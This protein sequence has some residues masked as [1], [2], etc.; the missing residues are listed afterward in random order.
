MELGEQYF[1]NLKIICCSKR[2]KDLLLRNKFEETFVLLVCLFVCFFLQTYLYLFLIHSVIAHGYGK[3]H[4][5]FVSKSSPIMHLAKS[6][7][8][9]QPQNSHDC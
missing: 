3:L 8:E 7:H 6:D 9:V 1:I 2:W 4:R 5:E